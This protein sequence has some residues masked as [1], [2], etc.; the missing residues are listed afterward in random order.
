MRF[1]G[2]RMVPV[3]RRNLLDNKVRLLI[4]VGGV[5]FAIV[6]IL[7]VQSLYQ[8]FSRRLGTFAETVPVDLWVTESDIGG[9]A[10]ASLIPEARISQV[11]GVEGVRSVIPVYGKRVR[12][13]YKAG[14]NNIYALAFDVPASAARA[15][16]LDLPDPGQIV[17]DEVF[18]DET[19]LEPGDTLDFRGLPLTISSVGNLSGTGLTQF[20]FNSAADAPKTIAIPGFVNYLLVD[21]EPDSDP[22][23]VAAAISRDV[24]GARA[25]SKEAFAA[26]SRSEVSDLF[27]PIVGVLL[28]VAALVGGAVVGVTIYTATVERAREY[29]VLRALGADKADLTKIVL[30]Q[31]AFVG[32]AGF[33]LGVPLAFAINALAESFVPEFITLIRA[34]DVAGAFVAALIM[35]AVAA[36]IPIR[37]V[38][39]VD[40]ATVFQP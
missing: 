19:G 11:A 2:Q 34:V 17:V 24:P 37:K 28:A 14:T 36:I 12:V 6:L 4:S 18:A 20:A 27:L 29:G 16:G 10:Y 9:F 31:S 5:T 25:L 38:A 30:T 1:V 26:E 22:A 23:A 3:A 21:V 8:G 15:A 35:S 32:A 39:T 33:A 7:V 13:S 40:P